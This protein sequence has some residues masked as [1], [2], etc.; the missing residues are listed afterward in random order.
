M[1]QTII[2]LTF[3]MFY[4]TNLKAQTSL[5]CNYRQY[6][7]WNVTTDKFENCKGY[8]DTSLFVMNEAET[9]FT[10]TTETVKTTYFVDSK[11][12]DKV[13]DVYTYEVTSDTGK[14]YYYVFDIKG[15]QVRV[16]LDEKG[17][18]KLIIFTVKTVF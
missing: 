12:Y 18:T 15:E 11:E 1:K 13:N 14:N 3:T 4:L 9:M 6:C 10:H 16:V 7:D 8:E 17:K 2:F 5:S